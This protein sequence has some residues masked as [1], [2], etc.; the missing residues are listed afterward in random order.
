MFQKAYNMW[1]P[2]I[3]KMGYIRG[4]YLLFLR[5]FFRDL[6]S[7]T[8]LDILKN[9]MSI[10]IDKY[11]KLKYVKER[12]YENE[13]L[14]WVFWYQ[15]YDN[16]PDIVK[17]CY[18]SILNKFGNEDKKNVHLITKDNMEKY[19]DIDDDIMLKVKN[20][21][22]TITHLSDILRI[23]L[24]KKY[25]GCWIDST[26]F[27]TD[28]PT[29]E[30]WEYEFYSQKYAKDKANFFNEGKWSVFFLMGKKEGIIF[31]YL[32][33]FFEEY[34]KKNDYVL[35]YYLMDYALYIAYNEID[36]IRE[37]IDEVPENNPE[38]MTICEKWNEN[39][40]NI[41][42]ENLKNKNWFF[43]LTWKEKINFNSDTLS[44]WF[45][46]SYIENYLK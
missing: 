2:L 28:I 29:E 10:V 7:K 27:I 42:L 44:L 37:I 11:K 43:K 21:K 19:V 6:Y 39:I 22:I 4:T 33:E 40:E 3:K 17:G 12:I 24:L 41:S 31:S 45:Y 5:A 20:G 34:L 15:G 25:G 13:K 18:K 30:V 16:M 35:D 8:I 9:E 38:V 14:V 36:I 23:K 1:I 46:R 26:C 32:D